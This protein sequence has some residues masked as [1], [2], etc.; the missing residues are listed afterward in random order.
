MNIYQTLLDKKQLG[1]KQL[2][3]LVDPDKTT[4]KELQF[5]CAKATECNIDYFFVGGSLITTGSV[6]ECV[7]TIKKN[8]TIPV[9]LFPGNVEQIDAHADAILFLSLI[10]GRNAEL[11]IGKHVTAAPILRE[12]NLE[13]I[14]TGYMLIESGNVTTVQY[15]SNT[16]P[17]P[18]NQDDIAVSTAMA[19]EMLGLKLI[20]LEAGSGALRPVT[21]SMIKKVKQ[22]ISVPLLVGG[23]I[24][25]PQKLID[26]YNAG[27]DIIIVGNA[28]EKEPEL[29][30]EL[31]DAKTKLNEKN[32]NQPLSHEVV[33]KN[34]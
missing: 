29:L 12:I 22:N 18:H 7:D 19:G 33:K 23:G 11:L 21:A 4:E 3:V 8:C 25:T 14:S 34:I 2:V 31:A 27:A 28:L 20:Y 9:I 1:L 30:Q 16:K 32:K 5:L 24:R 15:I 13:T 26:G 10:S 6:A 17:I